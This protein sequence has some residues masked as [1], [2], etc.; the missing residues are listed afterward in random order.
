MPVFHWAA[1]GDSKLQKS[2]REFPK[3][4]KMLVRI[5][6]IPLPVKEPHPCVAK[7]LKNLHANAFRTKCWP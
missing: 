1:T 6:N 3:C 7:Y 2:I 4:P 5:L